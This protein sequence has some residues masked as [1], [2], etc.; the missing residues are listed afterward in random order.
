MTKTRLVMESMVLFGE[1][2]FDGV[3]VRDIADV[4]GLKT[5]S[6]YNHFYSKDA[7]LDFVVNHAEDLYYLYLNAVRE[8]SYEAGS[9]G[10]LLDAVIHDPRKVLSP[11][12][13]YTY[14][15]IHCAKYRSHRLASV[16]TKT[17]IEYSVDFYGEIFSKAIASGLCNPFDTKIVAIIINNAFHTG[18]SL[19]MQ[20]Y[21]GYHT[22][23]DFC[24]M[25]NGVKDFVH[26]VA[27]PV[28]DGSAMTPDDALRLPPYPKEMM[29]FNPP[30]GGDGLDETSRAIL[31]RFAPRVGEAFN[32][33]LDTYLKAIEAEGV[34]L[35]GCKL[36]GNGEETFKSFTDSYITSVAAEATEMD[37]VMEARRIIEYQ[38]ERW[39]LIKVD[40][41]KK[42]QNAGMGLSDVFA[43][44]MK[45]DEEYGQSQ[46]RQ[47][48]IFEGM[49][50]EGQA[51]GEAA[52]AQGEGAPAEAGVA[53]GE[54]EGDWVLSDDVPKLGCRRRP[55][56][57][58]YKGTDLS[59][60]DVLVKING[61]IVRRPEPKADPTL[62]VPPIPV[63]EVREIETASGI[64]RQKA[65]LDV[66]PARP[67]LWASPSDCWIKPKSKR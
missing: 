53:Q 41:N 42:F 18:V 46:W 8:A 16:F 39:R 20:E 35:T 2:G 5:S 59:N 56:G 55:F 52:Q 6:F 4:V 64:A 9:F 28:N 21:L 44:L 26:K 11:L 10:E 15:I 12:T 36:D 63:D 17:F 30:D 27:F 13:C 67:S 48:R 47:S 14:S 51:Q 54:P 45:I 7:L 25:V 61:K 37:E 24:P 40:I 58:G 62:P 65:E 3:S 1:K 32:E 66:M 22:G 57:E 38:A 34:C 50:A 49:E 23:V 19:S 33:R 60:L 43:V 29:A 31:A